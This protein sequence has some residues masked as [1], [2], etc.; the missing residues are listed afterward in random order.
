[1]TELTQEEIDN[2]NSLAKINT[3]SIKIADII[4]NRRYV[5]SIRKDFTE[6]MSVPIGYCVCF[7]FI[8]ANKC[9]K[10]CITFETNKERDKAFTYWYEQFES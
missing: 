2:F 6:K 1:M 3:N 5:T 8:V 7:H 4:Y 10:K 9:T